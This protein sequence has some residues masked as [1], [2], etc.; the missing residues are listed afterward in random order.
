MAT[1]FDGL[2]V[3][4]KPQGLTSRQAVDQALRWFPRSTRVGHTG[5]LDPLATGVL[6]LCVGTATRLTGYVQ[7]MG[8]T[9]FTTVRLGAR[10]DTDDAEGII[11]P[12]E[13]ATPPAREDLA[14]CL[15]DFVGEIEQV[16]PAFSAARVSGKRAYSLARKGEEVNLQPRRVRINGID[17]L[18]YEYPEVDLEVRCGK[19][20]YIRSLAR[21]VGDQLGC[22]GLVQVLRRTRVGAFSPEDAV[23]LDFTPEEARARLLPIVAAVTSLPFV[24][25]S[26]A[27]ARDLRQGKAIPASIRPADP[28]PADQYALLDE[29]G[30]LVAIARYEPRR[31]VFQPV[32][33]LPAKDG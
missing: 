11:I 12:V 1:S 6:V 21:D 15:A 25:V 32:K 3:L 28:Q 13:G 22:G 27:A 31:R 8:K 17:L 18:R 10:S 33:V 7:D 19:G 20:T 4:D 9:Y 26:D 23:P 16:P 29:A 30:D 5:T 24:T 2:L 14:R